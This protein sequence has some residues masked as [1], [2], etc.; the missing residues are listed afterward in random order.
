MWFGM[1][2]ADRKDYADLYE[3]EYLYMEG[4]QEY[5]LPT[6]TPIT[7]YFDEEL[8]PGDKMYLYLIFVGAYRD[9]EEIDCVLLVEEFQKPAAQQALAADR[10][11]R[12]TH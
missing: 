8:K 5:W 10:N 11:Q 3:S 9:K 4:P 7:K 1:L 12:V 2:R 6:S